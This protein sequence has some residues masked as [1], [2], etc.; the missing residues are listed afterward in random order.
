MPVAKPE[1]TRNTN[2]RREMFV[3]A[4]R[5]PVAVTIAHAKTVITT[6]RIAVARF[7]GTPS[8]PIFARMAVAAAATADTSAYPSHPI[9]ATL[10]DPYNARRA[11]GDNPPVIRPVARGAAVVLL[12]PFLTFASALAPQHVHEGHDHDH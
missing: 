3:S 1:S 6:V 2:E 8:T 9:G 7:D 5:S 11:L 12:A 10:Q 4:W